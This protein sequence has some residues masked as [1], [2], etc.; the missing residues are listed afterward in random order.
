ML[1]GEIAKLSRDPAVGPVREVKAVRRSEI[2]VEI[3]NVRGEDTFVIQSAGY[4][5]NDHLM[6]L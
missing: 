6:E 5:A 1:A 2:F 4:P 3:Q